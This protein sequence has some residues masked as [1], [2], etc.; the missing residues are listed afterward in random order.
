[1][2]AQVVEYVCYHN[3]SNYKD[4]MLPDAF[5]YVTKYKGLTGSDGEYNR[6]HRLLCQKPFL[7]QPN[8]H[9]F[10][11]VITGRV[12]ELVSAWGE[13]HALAEER[14]V[15]GGD[16]HSG[17]YATVAADDGGRPYMR[18]DM[19]EHSQR[20]TLDI[21]SMVAFKHDF[22]QV[23]RT[24]RE[25][26]TATSSS[27]G[28]GSAWE[29]DELLDAYNESSELMGQLFITPVP[30]IKLM[31]RLG[32][33]K[34]RRLEESY[35]TLERV[36]MGLVDKRRTEL[37]ERA[38]REGGIRAE[39]LLDTLV[40]ATNPDGSPL[41]NDDL[42]GDINDIMAAGHRTQASAMC[43]ALYHMSRNP[44]LLAAATAQVDALGGRCPT[45]EDVKEG[46]LELLER[47]V[48]EGLRLHAPI[49]LFPRL[50]GGDDE[51]PTGHKVQKGDFILLSSYAMG[52]NGRVW[53]D[54]LRFDPDR[55]LPDNLV[56]MQE[57]RGKALGLSEKDIARQV[58]R[59][60]NGRDFVYTPFGAGPRSCIGGSFA[61]MSVALILATCL[62]KFDFRASTHEA[63]QFG[64]A[65]PFNYDTTIVFTEGVH[66]E[67]RPRVDAPVSDRESEAEAEAAG[68]G[69]E[70]ATAA[71]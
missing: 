12:D 54:P 20:V 41:S 3:A 24:R 51:M 48:K 23:E 5:R 46:R 69:R 28:G 67:M 1:M 36:G 17:E 14:G 64:E 2:C 56:R 37:A 53:K 57:E 59:I 63:H 49:N 61:Q 13:A 70:L 22:A 68:A 44:D 50:A 66:L 62:Q 7:Y 8:L 58:Q 34:I 19:N 52:R 31:S 65:L 9:D 15:G 6:Q 18:V 45:Y 30:L 26:L 47:V 33:E 4:R 11:G 43:V 21:I 60:L 35:A 16:N 29:P 42:W 38:E 27:G 10:A 40:T 32:V 55:F 71:T 39:C 25:M